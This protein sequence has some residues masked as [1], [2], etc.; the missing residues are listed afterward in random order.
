MTCLIPDPPPAP[1]PRWSGSGYLELEAEGLP[2]AVEVR[3]STYTD[4][5]VTLQPIKLP[6][7]TVIASG[8]AEHTVAGTPDDELVVPV[9]EQ[10]AKAPWESFK[11]PY[12]KVDWPIT[13]TVTT[14]PVTSR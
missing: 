14:P 4:E 6:V 5:G 13:F 1:E 9:D 10:L 3:I 12:G 7:G 2:G 11:D 8:E